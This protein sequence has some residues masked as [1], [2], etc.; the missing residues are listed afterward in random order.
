MGTTIHQLRA[1]VTSD[2]KGF[3]TGMGQVS[4][5][6][7]SLRQ[8]WK[9][10]ANA[11][12]SAAMRITAAITG[13]GVYASKQ[14][15]DFEDTMVEVG[16]ITRTLG[17]R[18]FKLLKDAALDMGEKTRYSA[19]EA[20]GALKQL[21]LAGL[22]ANQSIAALPPTLNLAA[23]AGISIGTAAGIA[24]KTMKAMGLEANQLAHVNDVLVSTFTRSNTDLTQLAEGLKHAAPLSHAL[25][26]SIEDTTAVLAKLADAGFQGEMGGTAL[27]NIMSRL[28]GAMPRATAELSRMGITT[29]DTT[30]KMRPLLDILQDIENAGL[31]AG[32][33]MKIFGQRGGPQLLALLEQGIKGVREFSD[34][35]KKAGG[36]ADRMMRARMETL[37]GQWDELVSVIDSMFIDLGEDIDPVLKKLINDTEAW[38]KANKPEIVRE[39]GNVL[40]SMIQTLR[41]F[42]KWLGENKKELWG[43]AEAFAS[44]IKWVAEFLAQRP[45]LMGFLIAL[46]MSGLL[47]VNNALWQMGGLLSG[48]INWLGRAVIA[49]RAYATAATAA[50]A[51]SKGAAAAGAVNGAIGAAGGMAGGV[52]GAIGNGAFGGGAG[53]LAGKFGL[54]AGLQGGMFTVVGGAMTALAAKAAVV[55]AALALVAAKLGILESVLVKWQKANDEA[56]NRVLAEKR[57]E[58]ARGALAQQIQDIRNVRWKRTEAEGKDPT[59]Q[60]TID[61][62]KEKLAV[63]KA[64]LVNIQKEEKAILA[65][66][67]QAEQRFHDAQ[68]NG[69]NEDRTKAHLNR[70]A[71]RDAQSAI[72]IK[73]ANVPTNIK[74]VSKAISEEGMNLF[75]NIKDQVTDPGVRNE[76]SRQMRSLAAEFEQDIIPIEK[77]EAELARLSKVMQKAAED[78][79]GPHS[80]QELNRTKRRMQEG[81][82]A[83]GKPL[84]HGASSGVDFKSF[85]KLKAAL[86]QLSNVDAL[87]ADQLATLAEDEMR[88]VENLR[89]SGA[90]ADQVANAEF[91]LNTKLWAMIAETHEAITATVENKLTRQQAEAKLQRRKDAAPG[92]EPFNDQLEEVLANAGGIANGGLENIGRTIIEKLAKG[93]EGATPA[94]Q[95]EF[96]RAFEAL[97]AKGPQAFAAGIEELS[98]AFIE[99]AE[100]LKAEAEELDAALESLEGPDGLSQKIKELKLSTGSQLSSEFEK[101][102]KAARDRTIT[103]EEFASRINRID[104]AADAA[105]AGR[106]ATEGATKGL[107]EHLQQQAESNF[108]TQVG[109][110]GKPLGAVEKAKEKWVDQMMQ[111]MSGPLSAAADKF[112]KELEKL[113]KEFLEGDMSTDEFNRRLQALSS[114]LDQ[115]AA[116]AQ[117]AADAEQRRQIAMGN[118]SSIWN[119]EKEMQDRWYNWQMGRF[120]AYFDAMFE[121]QLAMMGLT[122]AARGLT[123]GFSQLGNGVNRLSN[124]MANWYESNFGGYGGGGGGYGGGPDITGGLAAWQ[125]V[126]GAISGLVNQIAGLSQILQLNN[127][128]ET[129]KNEV[130]DQIAALQEQLDYLSKPPPPMFIGTSSDPF[131]NDPGIVGESGRAGNNP[132]AAGQGRGGGHLTV[133]NNITATKI[134]EADGPRIV[135]II[136]REIKRR[137]G[138]LLG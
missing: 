133:N 49:W 119:P 30:G 94:M 64:D 99:Q 112:N 59:G 53:W 114:E 60:S 43:M 16:A 135:D 81:V 12:A 103:P 76:F 50:A 85:D 126:Q 63:E 3:L 40:K 79:Q 132:N 87:W 121:Q 32:D 26:V 41:D 131:F 44:V 125:S 78:S 18:D 68:R 4:G 58:F 33:V 11:V 47:G 25:G 5:A 101:L 107:R 88:I 69:T 95:T 35:T 123:D 96:I 130:R 29:L 38:V 111:K 109:R 129:R 117:R 127:V 115:A 128:S 51:A 137:G 124:G 28:A 82:D 2:I 89:R 113:Q 42:A 110:D 86:T 122:G 102:K 97:K 14:F 22:G 46:K 136:E 62:L 98:L 1:I 84:A 6:T 39:M 80:F 118:F 75:N 31:S 21:S 65:R 70:E 74:E 54:G 106:E 116:K 56:R 23:A 27:R 20:A 36:V 120:N 134:T 61:L 19:T 93:V 90:A 83:S 100:K 45:A 92:F 15:A 7:I 73:L 17:T 66:L 48:V 55:T 9:D 77:F 105:A 91:D 72:N 10:T 67:E 52:G 138:R 57:Q 8:Q 104:T 13:I 71:V 108:G 24:A 34:E 37:K